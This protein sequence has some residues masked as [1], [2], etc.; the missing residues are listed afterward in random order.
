MLFR[1]LVQY[2][3]GSFASTSGRLCM[4]IR[5]TQKPCT[6]SV[7]CEQSF[8][9]EVLSSLL[10]QSEFEKKASC[11]T[12]RPLCFSSSWYNYVL[13]H[14]S[15]QRKGI[16][17]RATPS[18]LEFSEPKRVQEK[19]LCETH[20]PIWFRWY[21]HVLA[22]LLPPAEE[23]AHPGR[24]EIVYRTTRSVTRSPLEFSARR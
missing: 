6:A 17:L 9:A 22:Y 14:S 8:E 3:T 5:A 2:C 12:H 23:H 21:N 16:P 10:S 18:T 7:P 4:S 20:L 13:V 19:P 1:F 11:E 15:H 24:S